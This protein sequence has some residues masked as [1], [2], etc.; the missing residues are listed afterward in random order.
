MKILQLATSETKIPPDKAGSPEGHIFS[1][2]KHLSETG[3]E[4]TILGRR[5]SNHE[6]SLEEVGN[7][8]IVRLSTKHFEPTRLEKGKFPFLCWVR[9]G[10]NAML[11]ALR[12]SKYVRILN[13]VDA[14]NSH[15]ISVTFVLLIL[16]RKLKDKMFYTH[17]TSFLPSQSGGMATKTLKFMIRHIK[18]RVRGI[19]VHNELA[20]AEFTKYLGLPDQ[21][22]V[23]IPA[24]MDTNLFSSTRIL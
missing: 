18:K 12:I 7:L 13:E 3:H 4:V 17:A 5:L 15:V 8:R 10:L 2:S 6:P 20:R 21:K 16:N 23:L 24:G 14:I 22:V 19:I 11:F 1:L 9:G